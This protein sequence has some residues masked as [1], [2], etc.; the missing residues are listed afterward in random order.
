MV[1]ITK[2]AAFAFVAAFSVTLF[3]GFL[4][5]AEAGKSKKYKYSLAQIVE[6]LEE[7]GFYNIRVTDDN[8]PLYDFKTCYK[9][10]AVELTID[11][12]GNVRDKDDEGRCRVKQ[13]ATQSLK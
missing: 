10:R 7:K 8:P 13:A 9:G 4:V 2:F 11:H 6:R 5:S 3:T 1:K 12:K